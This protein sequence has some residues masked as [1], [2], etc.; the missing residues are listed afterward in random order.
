MRKLS[1]V[2][3][4]ACAKAF[5]PEILPVLKPKKGKIR[6]VAKPRPSLVIE[7]YYCPN[8]HYNHEENHICFRGLQNV[9]EEE[10]LLIYLHELEHWAQYAFLNTDASEQ[11]HHAYRD[12][13]FF[14]NMKVTKKRYDDLFMEYVNIWKPYLCKAFE[15]KADIPTD[16]QMQKWGSYY[17]L[18]QF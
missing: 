7:P 11:V 2:E 9:S 14:I 18:P 16:E 4:K 15:G 3:R 1:E 5:D 17:R 10:I 13:V 6:K 8:A 12:L